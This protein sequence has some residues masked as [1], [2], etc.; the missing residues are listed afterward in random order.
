MAPIPAKSTRFAYTSTNVTN[1]RGTTN[2]LAA[3][4]GAIGKLKRNLG[5]S[6]TISNTADGDNATIHQ[7]RKMLGQNTESS[8][9]VRKATATSLLRGINGKLSNTVNGS[10]ATSISTTGAGKTI[11]KRI[12]P[13]DFKARY[14]DLLE[15]HKVLKSKYDEKCEQVSS[16]ENLPEQLEETQLQL[17]QSE[18]ELKNIKMENE[19]MQSQI[20]SQEQ[21]IETIN[22]N[23]QRTTES[24]K[25]LEKKHDVSYNDIFCL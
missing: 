22:D 10:N 20:A 9:I 15:K 1:V 5:R 7:G 17:S 14:N 18:K 25:K 13:Y 16:W 3:T 12:P 6:A 24:M 19:V 21:E 2:K 4:E 8:K 11:N 23:L